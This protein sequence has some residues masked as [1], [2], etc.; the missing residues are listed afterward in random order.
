MRAS[1]CTAAPQKGTGYVYRVNLYKFLK[2]EID[3]PMYLYFLRYSSYTELQNAVFGKCLMSKCV[4]LE[5]MHAKEV[6]SS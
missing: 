2:F 1:L 4:V 6:P 5:I 3:L